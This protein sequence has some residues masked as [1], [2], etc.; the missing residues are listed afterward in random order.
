MPNIV[1]VVFNILSIVI[2]GATFVTTILDEKMSGKS[3]LD[4]QIVSTVKDNMKSLEEYIDNVFDKATNDDKYKLL[5]S[6]AAITVWNNK[7][8]LKKYKKW[9]ADKAVLVDFKN[10]CYCI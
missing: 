1:G 7:D 4:D 3:K 8:Y 9:F 6:Y 5:K 2:A 10:I